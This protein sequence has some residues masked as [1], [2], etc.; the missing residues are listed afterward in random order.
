MKERE[1]TIATGLTA[2]MI[3]LWLGF[4][5][6]RS[7]RFA[8]SLWGGVLGVTGSLLMLVPLIYMA[9]KRIKRIKKATTNYVSMRTLLAWHV[10]A[11]ILGP[12]MSSTPSRRTKSS[13]RGSA[14]GSSSTS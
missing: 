11:G 13:K 12:P 2:L 5:V 3:I 14:S 1:K 7:P 6:H 9:V 4:L 8:G 10:Y